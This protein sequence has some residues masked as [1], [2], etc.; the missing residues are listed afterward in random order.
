MQ[1]NK[2]EP[3]YNREFSNHQ[4]NRAINDMTLYPNQNY[5][6][7]DQYSNSSD[8]QINQHMSKQPVDNLLNNYLRQEGIDRRYSKL[9]AQELLDATEMTN[10]QLNMAAGE[11]QILNEENSNDLDEYEYEEAPNENVMNSTPKN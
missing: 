1:K 4:Q 7:R 2:A 3:I 8:H 6:L 10:D 5:M 9:I 11:L